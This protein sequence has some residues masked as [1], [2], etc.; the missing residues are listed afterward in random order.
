MLQA[1]PRGMRQSSKMHCRMPRENWGRSMRQLGLSSTPGCPKIQ[2]LKWHGP[3]Y[4]YLL[5][6]FS[7]LILFYVKALI[8]NL[9]TCFS[10]CL[11]KTLKLGSGSGEKFP[12]PDPTKW[13]GS[14]RIRFRIRIRNTDI[15]NDPE[16]RPYCI[17]A[18]DRMTKCTSRRQPNFISNDNNSI[19]LRCIKKS[20]SKIASIFNIYAAEG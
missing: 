18:F 3:H 13:C 4:I 14:D 20:R 19:V 5:K 15:M 16:P 9:L 17:T 2:P 10:F 8:C 1:Q 6:T 11:K 12:D 7:T